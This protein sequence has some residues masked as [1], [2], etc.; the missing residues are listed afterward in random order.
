[1]VATKRD[2]ATPPDQVSEEVEEERRRRQ[3]EKNRPLIALLESWAEGDDQES[4][5]EQREALE[6]LMR[7]LDEDRPSNRKLFS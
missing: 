5:Q 7:A 2:Q 4:V 3:I 1:M 6:W